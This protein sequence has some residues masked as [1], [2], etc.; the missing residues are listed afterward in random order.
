MHGRAGW[1]A[2]VGACLLA[3][4]AAAHAQDEQPP[5][6]LVVVQVAPGIHMLVGRGGN[7]G[8][9][10]G[11]D[12]TFVIDDQYAPMA[13]AVVEAIAGITDKPASFVLNTHWHEDHTGSNESFGKAGA[14]IVAH[15][16]VRVRLSTEQFISFFDARSPPAPPAA[17]PIVTFNDTVTFHLNG[18][19]IH[20]FHVA[21]AHTDGDAIVYFR[22]ADV[23]HTGDIFFNG[24][25]PFIDYDSG[26][27]IEGVIAAVDRMLQL[28]GPGTKIIPGH[29]PLADEAKL[30]SYRAMLDDVRGRIRKIVTDGKGLGEAI[31]AK[32]TADH[33]A[34]WG[35]GFIKPDR[36][37]ELLYRGMLSQPRRE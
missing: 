22:K 15:D 28:A 35:G 20:A 2:V 24:M 27:S 9:A 10:S 23:I 21:H 29:G 11:A 3:A 37:V 33:D 7:V 30:Q 6:K 17:L 5:A 4:A 13:P 12:K 34:T 19:E 31:A 8:V 25:Y 26:G 18:D 14:L 1:I 36:W 16:N 32:P